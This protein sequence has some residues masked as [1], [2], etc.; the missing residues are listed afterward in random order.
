MFNLD[1]E[2]D[3]EILLMGRKAAPEEKIIK[4]HWDV[5]AKSEDSNGIIECKNKAV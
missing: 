4:N 2:L 3:R 5:K 1:E